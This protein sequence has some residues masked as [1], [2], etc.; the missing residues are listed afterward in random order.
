MRKSTKKQNTAFTLIELLVVISIIAL[1]VA[2]LM[3]ALSKAK[4]QAKRTACSAQLHGIAAAAVTYASDND[5]KFPRCHQE[6]SP[7]TGS[8]A[9]WTANTKYL[10][11]GIL[12]REKYIDNPEVYYC[13]GNRNESLQYGKQSS[14]Y[15]GAGGGWPSG[16]RIPEDLPS[17]Q[18]WVQ[19]TYYYRS[20]YDGKRWRAV[21]FAT[22][23]GGVGLMVDVFAD[24]DRGVD[25]HHK[26]GYNVAYADGHVVYVKEEVKNDGSFA[27]RDYNG[28][29]TY[30]NSNTL[31]DRVWKDFFDETR[32]Y[33][34]P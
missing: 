34:K 6:I 25:W 8:Y 13:P 30:H 16:G 28:G 9:I 33:P 21:N 32:K 12:V 18:I 15:G 11:H 4:D 23:G 7:G 24:P 10:A 29:V 19:S 31:Q 26:D 20:L 1:L 3:P 2:I 14:A 22:D 5:D 17:G 27:I